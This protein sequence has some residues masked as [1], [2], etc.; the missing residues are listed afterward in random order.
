MPENRF[1]SSGYAVGIDL[2]ATKT[3]S[4]MISQQGEILARHQTETNASE[5]P[6]TALETIA[7]H[8][9]RYQKDY[10]KDI[11][12]IGV[13]T[14][15]WHDPK[16]GII[17]NAVHLGWND[18]EF[19]HE[20]KSK[21][22]LQNPVF[23]HTDAIAETL[24]EFYYGSAQG[25]TD[26][27]YLG[28]GSGLGSG[29]FCNGDVNSGSTGMAGSIGHFAY[30]PSQEQCAC[31]LHGCIEQRVSGIALTKM[32]KL[33]EDGELETDQAGK[34]PFKNHQDVIKA[35]EN[36]DPQAIKMLSEMGKWLG[37]AMSIYISVLNPQIIVIGGGLGR[38]AYSY[39]LPAAKAEARS[40]TLPRY[41]ENLIF[42]K[43]TVASS[44]IGAACL[45]WKNIGKGG[46]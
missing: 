29:Y 35:A 44:A 2:G 10:P 20:L 42:K 3:A 22:D 26:F 12:G 43:S 31:G 21:F 14:P 24:G 34:V 28:V 38:A 6:Q 11:L 40:R 45:V 16:N 46:G 1:N 15:G 13:G 17:T 18:F 39:L 7:A 25:Y 30:D 4:V 33:L 41:W 19:M 32:L 36:H 27:V 37:I 8:I 5:D 23:H 9:D